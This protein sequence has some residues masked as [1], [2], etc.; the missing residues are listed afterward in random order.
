MTYAADRIWEEV[1]YVAYYLHWDLDKIL[2][3]EH[4]V[5]T[6]VITEIGRIH[7]RSAEE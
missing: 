5:R 6:R 7:S 4:P 2:D 3:M 1:A